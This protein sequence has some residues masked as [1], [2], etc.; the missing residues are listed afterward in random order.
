MNRRLLSVALLVLLLSVTGYIVLQE[1]VAPLD[2]FKEFRQPDGSLKLTGDKMTPDLIRRLFMPRDEP[3]NPFDRWNLVRSAYPTA[4]YELQEAHLLAYVP[5][6]SYVRLPRLFDSKQMWR[7]F[8]DGVRWLFSF[9]WLIGRAQAAFTSKGSWL[10]NNNGTAATT[11]CFAL[12]TTL[13][14]N[15]FAILI[16][17]KDETG[18]G[19]TDGD[20]AQI[21]NVVTA[22][23]GVND[24]NVW[25]KATEFANMQSSTAANGAIVAV[26]FSHITVAVNSGGTCPSTGGT[27]T[28]TF[29]ASTTAKAVT[30]WAFTTA[31]NGVKVAPS[32]TCTAGTAQTLAA[33]TICRIADD[34]L[35]AS[36]ITMASLASVEHLNIRGGGIESNTTTYTVS[37][38]FTTFTHTSSTFNSGTAATSM[39]TRGEFRIV[40]STGE[41]TNPTTSAS[42]QASALV[43]FVECNS[44]SRFWVGTD[45]LGLGTGVGNWSSPAMWSDVS[46]GARGCLAPT[47]SMSVTFDASSSTAASTF[48]VNAA[49]SMASFTDSG[50]N[51]ASSSIALGANSWTNVGAQTHSTGNLPFSCSTNGG[52]ISISGT[53]TLSGGNVNCATSTTTGA[54]ATVNISVATSFIDFGSGNW[55]V[56]GTWT[57]SS[58]SASWDAGTGTVTF[59]SATGGTM[60]FGGSVLVNPEFNAVTFNSTSASPTTFTMALR[61]LR[62]FGTLTISDATSTTELATANFDIDGGGAI[63]VGN[64]GIFTANA[65]NVLN[66]SAVTMT[67][68][69]SGV[70]TV[71]TGAWTV[72]GNWNTS[73]VGSTFTQGTGLVNFLTAAAKAITML[74][75]DNDF[76][77]LSID[78][79]TAT[80]SSSIDVLNQLNVNSGALNKSTFAMT[81]GG[82]VSMGGGDI[83]S[84]SGDVTITGGLNVAAAASA[85]DFGSE[86]WTIGGVFDCLSTDTAIWDAGTGSVIFNSATGDADY[87]PCPIT[88]EA[89]FNNVTFS[90]TGGTAQTFTMTTNGLRWT[91]TLTVSDAASTT[92]L[93]TTG[94][95]LNGGGLTVGNGGIL[96]AN[97]STVAVSSVTM[98]GGTS[99]VITVTTGAWTVSGSWNTSGA[100]STYTQGTGIVTF[101]ATATIIMLSTDNTFDDLTISAG[102]STLAGAIVVTN[103]L[104]I[105]GGTLA[106]STF[107]ITSAGSLTMS[108][109]DLTSTSGAVVI[110]G[111]VNIS[112]AASAID[113]GSETWTVSGTWTNASTDGVGWDAGTGTVTFDSATGGTMTFAGT[114]LSEAE[115]NNAT[116]NSTSGT[117]QTFTMATRALIVSLTLTVTDSVSTTTLDTANL[118]LTMTTLDVLTNGVLL[119]GTGNLNDMVTFNVDGSMTMDTIVVSNMAITRTTG[120]GNID[121]TLW[122]AWAAGANVDVRWTFSPSVAGDTWQ[123]VL[124]DVT[125][126]TSYDL[127]RNAAAVDTQT[128]VGTVV[129]L[130]RAAGWAAGDVM[131]IDETPTN[132]TTTCF[133]VGGTG[134]WSDSTHWSATSG[135]AGGAGE[136]TS[137]GAVTVDVASC[138]AACT[139]TVDVNAV[140]ASF[141]NSGFNDTG[142]TLA[143][144]TF[145]FAVSGAIA[146]TTSNIAVT[147]G[148]SGGTGLTATTTLTLSGGANISCDVA[149]CIGSITGNVSISDATS[150]IDF[151]SAGWTFSGSWM[152]ATTSASWDAGTATAIF[153]AAVAGTMTFAGSG[154]AEAEFNSVTFTSS[155]GTA[156]TFTMA[157]RGL[158]WLTT[159]SITD[160]TSTTALATMDLVLGAAADTPDLS[161]GNNG[162]LTANASF[163]NVSNVTMT[164]GVSGVITVTTGIWTV[165]GNWNTSGA[166]SIYTQG[167]GIVT[168]DATATITV[169]A[170]DNTFDDLT[171]S[172]GT[173]TLATNIVVTNGLIISGGILAKSA[174]TLNMTTL[175]MSGG[176]L[177]STSGN[178]VVTGNV[179]ISSAAS[180]IDFGSE[181]WTVSGTWT[182]ASTDVAWDAGTGTVTFN[183]ATGGTMTFAGA[184]IAEAEFNHLTFNSTGGTAQTFTMSTRALQI[185]GTLTVSDSVSTTNLTTSGLGITTGSV[186]IGAGGILTM[187]ASTITVNGNWDS[188]AGSISRGTSTVVFAATGT[189][190]MVANNISEALY[191]VTI[192]SLVTLTNNTNNAWIAN[193]L[194]VNGTMLSATSD[195]QRVLF[196]SGESGSNML[197][198]GGSAVVNDSGY[199]VLRA[200]GPSGTIYTVPAAIYEHLALQGG[201]A[202]FAYTFNLSGN[203]ST[204]SCGIFNACAI[205]IAS[206]ATGTPASQLTFNTMNFNITAGGTLWLGDGTTTGGT[207]NLGSSII[208]A[209]GFNPTGDN[210][211]V[212]LQTATLTI[213]PSSADDPIAFYTTESAQVFGNMAN[214]TIHGQLRIGRGAVTNTSFINAGGSTW[215][216]TDNEGTVTGF[217][218]PGECNIVRAG[219]YIIF[220]TSTWTCEGRWTNNSTSSLWDAGTTT[221]VT[222]NA[223][224]TGTL[225]TDHYFGCTNL[226]EDEFNNLTIRTTNIGTPVTVT[227]LNDTPGFGCIDIAGTLTISDDVSTTT[228]ATN[229]LSINAGAL[230]VGNG[231][232]LTANASAVTVFSVAMNGGTSGTIT[233]TTGVW[234]VSGN[235][236]TSGAGSTYTQGTGIVT[237]NATA[238][239]TMLATDNTFDDLTVSAGTV[240]LATT[241]VTTNRVTVNGGVF[242]TANLNITANEIVLNSPGTMTLGTSDVLGFTRFEMNAGYTYDGVTVVVTFTLTVNT[243]TMDLTLMSAGDPTEITWTLNP[244]S[245]GATMTAAMRGL[246]AN[247]SY[248]MLRDGIVV[249]TITSDA[250][251]NA[252]FSVT[253]GWSPHTVSVQPTPAAGGGGGYVPPSAEPLLARK[254]FLLPTWLVLMMVGL[255]LAAI[256]KMGGRTRRGRRRRR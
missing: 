101:D 63:T 44:T 24:A 136:P 90:S 253:G 254:I 13:A 187:S 213:H 149:A 21:T 241:I 202:T 113:F 197:V 51:D 163:V 159:L 39:G 70:I 235:W 109:G 215:T 72:S 171:I 129:T 27:I 237:F 133:W 29:S 138:S 188:S 100:G 95:A 7:E 177:T 48:T 200:R 252:T 127:K 145:N 65:S 34:A 175:T 245:A 35:D 16:I 106:K 117:A 66:V 224:R 184:N 112:S 134:N 91:T 198:L 110:T 186:T 226:G 205:L 247:T 256:L 73:G 111:A 125:A 17:G 58:T 255:F 123:F 61:G 208:E 212:N 217:G 114:N 167:T 59:N 139:I 83:I 203:I 82:T 147:M 2:E 67:G 120:T 150:W 172:A 85:I 43:A 79:G 18:T 116:F 122:T 93:A 210:V 32:A 19:T 170:A 249:Q 41:T 46:G 191:N 165:S 162:V 38:N 131:A 243:G 37:T 216:V 36:A 81:V 238:T 25:I 148:A 169:L 74:S 71:T 10:T 179:N 189:L 84:T 15:D 62:H 227:M 68:G 220:G 193:I 164:G 146:F 45:K 141:T 143:I 144:G 98:T 75:T 230:V 77:D 22:T 89:H 173:V 107:A 248:D 78:D 207:F 250:A 246:T 9:D 3:P 233:V 87:T 103:A 161:I 182:N 121:I 192:N 174:F 53:L 1:A 142:S 80:L 119:C 86:T 124:E 155:A 128:S 176:D 223:G 126:A 229:S 132:C 156:Q 31:N 23:G 20:N 28:L 228:L 96:T 118:D 49:A 206:E 225:N 194:T 30:G 196:V 52:S 204:P 158:R 239:I 40:T 211:V 185:G 102:T 76:Y 26:W 47:S 160:G 137:A 166:G 64:G 152:N 56:S 94:L 140:M 8:V 105:S 50:F 104:T 154:L 33:G 130:S 14:V 12:N 108:G 199:L 244:S 92:A 6:L 222:L 151:G 42:D 240:T 190:T 242:S 234:T 153:D 11:Q 97:A 232:V 236:N 60:T 55:T 219:N 201:N 209:F 157:T 183:S 178:V 88:T 218:A 251:G 180:A 4:S 221:T 69:T 135:G 115:F 181:A 5:P 57:N 99:G 195:A 168:F 54:V 231:G 214:V